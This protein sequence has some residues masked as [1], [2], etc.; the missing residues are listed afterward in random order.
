MDCVFKLFKLVDGDGFSSL[1]EK[2]KVKTVFAGIFSIVDRKA[3]NKQQN[4]KNLFLQINLVAKDQ[5]SLPK[6]LN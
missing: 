1:G 2:G 3:S 6:C 4:L 5:I